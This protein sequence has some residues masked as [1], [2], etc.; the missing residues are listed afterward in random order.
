LPAILQTTNTISFFLLAILPFIILP[1]LL[2]PIPTNMPKKS[3]PQPTPSPALPS[4]LVPQTFTDGLPLPKMFV[5]DLDYTLWPF[6][7][8]THVA[9][10]L[11]AKD[12][13][14]RSVDRYLSP[15]PQLLFLWVWKQ[16][17]K[18]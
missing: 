10:P 18:V 16:Y 15:P 2:V 4:Q 14:A 5:F 3:Q 1:L 8:D 9:P 6:W 7:V 13:G 17:A 11:K 12:G